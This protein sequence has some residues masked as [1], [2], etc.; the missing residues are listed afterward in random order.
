MKTVKDVGEL[1]LIKRFRTKIKYGREVILGI[2]DDAAVIKP[3]KEYQLVTTDSLV[4]GVDFSKQNTPP[5]LVGR[6]LLAINLS[7]I[8]AMGGIPRYAL[9]TL[10]IFPHLEL[11]WLDRFLNGILKLARQFRVD[12]IGGDIS[13]SS[14]FWASL[15]LLGESVDRRWISRGGAKPGDQIFATGNLGGSIL[16]KHLNFTP[17]VLEAQRIVKNFNPTSMI[18]ISDGFLQDLNHVLEESKVGARVYASQIPIATQA[19]MLS[20]KDKHSPLEHALS[21]GEDFEL[22]FTT[23]KRKIPGSFLGTKITWVGEIVSQAR[24]LSLFES[25]QNLKKVKISKKGYVHF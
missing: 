22:L 1:G 10:G 5:E 20:D 18:D 21:D 4:D 15:V 13:R 19:R 12:L 2:G 17:R 14:K 25:P 8:A 23:R 7:D 3:S 16:G 6:K 24:G 11:F 9:L